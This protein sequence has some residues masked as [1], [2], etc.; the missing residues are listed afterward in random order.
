MPSGGGKSH[1]LG[2]VCL[3]ACGC[4]GMSITGDRAAVTDY[5]PFVTSY[6]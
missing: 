2:G 6:S 1:S 4:S 5:S 3:R